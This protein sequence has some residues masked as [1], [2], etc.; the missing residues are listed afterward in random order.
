MNLYAESSA[1]SAWLLKESAEASIYPL[2]ASAD[3]VVSSDLTLVE[4]DRTIW[5]AVAIG[6]ASEDAATEFRRRLAYFTAPWTFLRLSQDVVER[7]RQPFPSDPIR[8]LD[9]L[10]VA[11]ALTVRTTL[12]DIAMLSLDERVRRVARSLGLAVLPSLP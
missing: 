2:L 7:A 4:C 3:M 11:S 1:V 5:R 6:R 10:H 12:P 8:A 9:A